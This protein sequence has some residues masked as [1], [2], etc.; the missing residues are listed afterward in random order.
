MFLPVSSFITRTTLLA[1]RFWHARETS[2]AIRG[3]AGEVTS[4]T[5]ENDTFSRVNSGRAVVL[6]LKGKNL[7][8]PMV[9]EGELTSRKEETMLFSRDNPGRAVVDVRV[10]ES[11][12]LQSDVPQL[13]FITV[14]VYHCYLD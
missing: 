3:T 10:A 13:L 9:I 1:F 2:S 11:R 12:R 14:K 8:L 4:W 6:L 7:V 5:E